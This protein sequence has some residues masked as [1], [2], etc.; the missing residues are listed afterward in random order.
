MLFCYT[1]ISPVPHQLRL[2]RFWTELMPRVAKQDQRP[3]K[4]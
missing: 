4:P 1:Y 2:G 3:C